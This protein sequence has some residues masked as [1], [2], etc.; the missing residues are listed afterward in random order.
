[1]LPRDAAGSSYRS[2]N[3]NVLISEQIRNEIQRFESVH[4]YIYELYDLIDRVNDIQ[5]QEELRE[6]VVC[7]EGGFANLHIFE[8]E[9]IFECQIFLIDKN[10]NLAHKFAFACNTHFSTRPFWQRSG[11]FLCSQLPDFGRLK[12]GHL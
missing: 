7:I 9:Y 8:Q 11:N 2:I 6:H 3:S 5:L 1:M 12:C 10:G 4:P